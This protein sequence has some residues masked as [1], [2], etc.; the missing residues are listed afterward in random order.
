MWPRLRAPPTGRPRLFKRQTTRRRERFTLVLFLSSW[1]FQ[2]LP[3]LLAV[4]ERVSNSSFAL[5]EANFSSLI[6]TEGVQCKRQPLV[7]S[8]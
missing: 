1:R 6:V 5:F 3:H 2:W 7:Q 4:R 8:G